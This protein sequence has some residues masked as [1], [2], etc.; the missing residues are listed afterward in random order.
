MKIINDNNEPF[1]VYCG[2]KTGKTVIVT[3]KSVVL[4]FHSNR[5]VQKRGFLLL[6]T[7]FKPG[8]Y[9]Q[10]LILDLTDSI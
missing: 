3:G 2:R 10:E 4:T 8:E 7:A 9:N 6:F 1:G 5:V